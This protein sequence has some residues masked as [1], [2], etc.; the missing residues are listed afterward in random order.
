MSPEQVLCVRRHELFAAGDWQGLATSGTTVA[1]AV[2]RDRSFFK[3]RDQVEE[4][5]EYRQI[6]PYAAF[7]H[8]GCYFLTR[9]LSGSTESRLHALYSLGIGGHI[10]PS[11]QS[12]HDPS[13]GWALAGADLGATVERALWRE[14]AEEVV[15]RGRLS[16]SFL[17]LLNDTSG[18][19]SRVHLGI[20][21]LITGDNGRISVREKDKLSGRLLTLD[22]VGHHYEEMESW[23]RLVYEQLI[24]CRQ[25]CG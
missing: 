16:I 15:Y 14:W 20:V 10:N 17:G 5:P 3:P 1:R 6:I 18:P 12:D 25:P 23:S 22:Q 9:R 4:D 21:L 7:N 24:A 11:D 8:A 2:I 19:V 13:R